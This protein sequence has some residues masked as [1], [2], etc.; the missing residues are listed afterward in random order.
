MFS[1]A[2]LTSLLHLLYTKI[3]EKEIY[4]WV[5]HNN[6]LLI[7]SCS[8]DPLW[9]REHGL[10]NNLDLQ[11]CKIEDWMLNQISKFRKYI[12]YIKIYH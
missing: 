8:V 10:N 11:S 12:I 6:A 7:V 3:A 9:Q 1:E 5:K 2:V 4:A